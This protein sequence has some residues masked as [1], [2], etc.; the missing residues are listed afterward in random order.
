MGK[1]RIE[2]IQRIDNQSQRKVTLCKRKKGLIKKVIELSVLCDLKIFML[3]QDESNQ[4]STHFVSHKDFDII[5]AFNSLSHREFFTN[6]DYE[7]VG[8][9]R[10]ELD[11]QFK[12]SDTE[13]LNSVRSIIDE[14]TKAIQLQTQDIKIFSK[15]RN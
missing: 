9:N 11:S 3:I 15:K 7:K 1:K 13:S 10:D 4:R 14:R 8:G 6:S 2:R 5:D 12:L